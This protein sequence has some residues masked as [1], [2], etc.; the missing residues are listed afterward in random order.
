MRKVTSFATVFFVLSANLIAQEFTSQNSATSQYI[1][2]IS[3]ISETTGYLSGNGGIIKKTTDSGQSWDV[4]NSPTTITLWGMYFLDENTGWIVGDNGFIGRTTDGGDNWTTQNKPSST[5]SSERLTDVH[6]SDANNGFAVG[7]DGLILKSTD[8]G[9]SWTESQFFNDGSYFLRDVY[10]Y[11]STRAIVVGSNSRVL[12]TT[13]NGGSWSEVNFEAGGSELNSVSIIGSLS[14]A[15][16]DNGLM[17]VSANS[18]SSWS[19]LNS[20]TISELR[21]VYFYDTSNGFIAGNDGVLFRTGNTGSTWISLP[22]GTTNTLYTMGGAAGSVWVGGAGGLLLS[23]VV[24]P[25]SIKVSYPNGGE[26]ITERTEVTIE[27]TSTNLEGN[28]SIDLYR[29]GSQDLN[30]ALVGVEVGSYSW[31]V[32]ES[33]AEDSTYSIKITSV[34]DGGVTDESDGLF[35]IKPQ[36]NEVTI[37]SSPQEGGS[38]FGAGVYDYGDTVQLT[39]V[40][41]DS[42]FFVNW[43]SDGIE[44]GTEELFEF[45][46][47]SD[48]SLTANFEFDPT[49][50]TIKIQFP[51]VIEDTVGATVDIP[52]YLDFNK[53]TEFESFQFQLEYEPTMILINKILLDNSLIASFDTL[54]SRPEDGT[55][56]FTGASSDLVSNDGLFFTLNTTFLDTGSTELIWSNFY[57]NEGEPIANPIN[58]FIEIRDLPRKC[59]DVTNDGFVTNED[60]TWILRHGVKLSPQFPLVGEDSLAADVTT[61]GWISAYDAAQILKDVVGLNRVFNCDEPLQNKAEPVFAD[62]NARVINTDKGV[63]IPLELNVERGIVESV[64]FE[65]DIP[66]G[67]IYT[68]VSGINSEWLH[69]ENQS[70]GKLLFS[71]I[72]NSGNGKVKLVQLNFEGKAGKVQFQTK[73]HLNEQTVVELYT[74][75]GSD[76]PNQLELFQNYPNPFN[77]STTISYSIPEQGLVLLTMYNALGQQVADLVNEVKQVGTHNVTWDATNQASGIYIYE[78]TFGN[79]VLTKKLIL[80]K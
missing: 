12:L 15:V 63:A 20:P 60:A 27:W 62:F 41:A 7:S 57:F 17:L 10:M 14:F 6:F 80:I 53:S 30:I 23:N 37:S 2:S 18:G 76:K 5:G 78:I 49:P 3:M 19:N 42:Y 36:R 38:V 24:L 71:M 74:D 77:P 46:I 35:F 39:A 44:V 72:G 75:G 8:G 4:V 56:N 64:E 29:E 28:V 34:N 13:N 67:F 51:E 9:V 61:N 33:L 55:I 47:E 32:P 58:G 66:S 31:M 43:T 26:T 48:T 70:N 73:A 68:G 25:P 54:G 79:T 16:G 11:S 40:P 45:I 22:S 50:P 59:G 65:I 1:R 69:A 52:V 21:G